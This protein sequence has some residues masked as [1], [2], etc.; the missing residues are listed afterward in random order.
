[1]K[2][3]IEPELPTDS[4]NYEI[5]SNGV[6][7]VKEVEG[8]TCEIGLRRGGGTK[9][10]IDALQETG[11]SKTHIAIDPYGDIEYADSDTRTTHYDYDNTMRDECLTNLY[12]YC[13]QKKQDFIFYNLEDTEFFNRFHDGVPIYN[14]QAKRKSNLYSFVHFDGPHSVDA[15]MVEIDFFL[16]RTAPGAIFVFDDVQLYDHSKI[17][18]FLK[19]N[20]WKLILTI[21]RKLGYVKAGNDAN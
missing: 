20:N 13:S 1:M 2:I 17:D 7:L 10:I 5:I 21:P 19:L 16:S 3:V 12:L 15:L 18:D 9:V 8:M 11:Q 14:N 4:L 6:H